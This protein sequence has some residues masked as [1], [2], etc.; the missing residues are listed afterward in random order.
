M[1]AAPL[2]EGYSVHHRDGAGLDNPHHSGVWRWNGNVDVGRFDT[3]RRLAE[4]VVSG[5][6]SVVSGQW[7]VVG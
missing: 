1:S 3:A 2:P 4:A 5:Q 7:S 6:W